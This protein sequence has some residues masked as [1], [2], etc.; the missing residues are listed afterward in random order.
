[1]AKAKKLT[2]TQLRTLE[3]FQDKE[4]IHALKIKNL[5]K[6]VE[7]LKL[8]QEVFRNQIALLNAEI[9]KSVRNTN[10]EKSKKAKTDRER[11]E[12]LNEIKKQHSIKESFGYDPDT[13]EIK[14]N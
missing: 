1:M 10:D 12:Y 2:K 3:Q 14:E 6:D 5:E 11:K 8:R 7:I 9:E 4:A 13:G